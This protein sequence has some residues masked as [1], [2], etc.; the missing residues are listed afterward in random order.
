MHKG[1]CFLLLVVIFIGTACNKKTK[2]VQQEYPDGVIDT[3]MLGEP[4]IIDSVDLVEI[5]PPTPVKLL[6]SFIKTSCYGK[7]P[8]MEARFYSDGRVLYIGKENVGRIGTF[9][10]KIDKIELDQLKGQAIDADFEN[11]AEVYPS[12][13]RQ[14]SDLPVTVTGFYFDDHLKKVVNNHDAPKSL[15]QLEM[16]LEQY[17]VGLVWEKIELV[18]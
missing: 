10:A 3:F 2:L 11:L 17:L 4:L 13:G 5:P 8:V 12:N 1:F 14:I 15:I 18:E 9:E 7:C 6:I 16:Y